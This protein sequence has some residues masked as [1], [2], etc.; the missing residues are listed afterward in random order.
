MATSELFP[1]LLAIL[2]ALAA[3]AA[4][5]IPLTARSKADNM[6]RIEALMDAHEANLRS[7]DPAKVAESKE[8]W[9]TMC[10]YI[11]ANSRMAML[12]L[13]LERWGDEA[14]RRLSA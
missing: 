13:D 14:A 2:A 8:R 1:V 11:Q 6:R 7:G 5:I 9:R 3:F 12:G 10:R 4:V